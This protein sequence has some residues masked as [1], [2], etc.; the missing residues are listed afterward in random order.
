MSESWRRL[1]ADDVQELAAVIELTLPGRKAVGF[2][3]KGQDVRVLFAAEAARV[4]QRH[5]GANATEQFSDRQTVEIRNELRADQ[6]RGLT[7]PSEGCAMAHRAALGVDLGTAR[8]L[9]L[10]I[11]TLQH[12]ARGVIGLNPPQR[13]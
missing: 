10:G 3:N 9:R 5:R 1:E 11:D 4:I 7:E 2:Q 6:S 8:R 12:R 13:H